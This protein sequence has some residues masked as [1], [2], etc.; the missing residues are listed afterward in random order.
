[1]IGALWDYLSD[2]VAAN[3]RDIV[4]SFEFVVAALLGALFGYFG[5]RLGIATAS[6]GDVVLVLLAYAAIGFGF[7]VSGLT[8]VLTAPDRDFAA[9][10]AWSDPGQD[11][12]LAAV[13]PKQN[14][15]SKLLFIFSWTAIAHW[16]VVAGSFVLLL[17][18]GRDT[19]L[20]ARGSSLVHRI[21]AGLE[22]GATVYAVSLFLITV[23]T[24]AQVGRT[25]I[26]RLQKAKP[27]E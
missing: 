15:Y 17:A 4:V 25:Y 12:G 21:A 10:L 6:T 1:M 18:L 7:S 3:A 19:P 26:K 8:L 2:E 9:Q 13:A 27:A 5:T 14:S 23:L 20:L 22:A 11:E 24:L 16:A